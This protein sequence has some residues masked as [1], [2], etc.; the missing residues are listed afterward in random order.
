MK[1]STSSGHWLLMRGGCWKR[2]VCRLRVSTL[3]RPLE[4]FHKKWANEVNRLKRLINQTL[5]K[6]RT[7]MF[8]N[9]M[10]SAFLI[11][12]IYPITPSTPDL[13]TSR[14]VGIDSRPPPKQPKKRASRRL[15]R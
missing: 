4:L 10:R 3:L 11:S 13:L 2:M 14:K 8:H 7:K 9:K 5:P 1:D 12:L 15:P 6:R